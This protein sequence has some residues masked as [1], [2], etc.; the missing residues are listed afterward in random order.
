M[1]AVIVAE[2]GRQ[3]LLSVM[4]D[5]VQMLTTFNA[6]ESLHERRTGAKL[7]TWDPTLLGR[8]SQ[9]P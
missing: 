4:C 8:L 7:A 9:A 2:R 1:A 5:P 6:A 3:G